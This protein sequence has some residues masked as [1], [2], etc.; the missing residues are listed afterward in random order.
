[1]KIFSTLLLTYCYVWSKN[2]DSTLQALGDL[3][4]EFRQ[5]A[6]H[7]LKDDEQVQFNQQ[8]DH[9]VKMFH[10]H[11]SDDSSH[12]YN[13]RAKFDVGVLEGSDSVMDYA[14]ALT[15]LIDGAFG[16]CENYIDIAGRAAELRW[17]LLTDPQDY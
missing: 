11:E 4:L 6:K 5:R 1:M 16:D 7:V 8:M 12:C 15:K 10:K 17:S 14:S 9:I 2:L 3:D 13:K